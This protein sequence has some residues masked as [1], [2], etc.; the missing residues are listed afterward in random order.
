MLG[1]VPLALVAAIL[2]CWQSG[3]A[4]W[5]W[6]RELV[7]PDAPP[8]DYLPAEMPPNTSEL[9]RIKAGDYACYEVLSAP[10]ED[11]NVARRTTKIA[12]RAVEISASEVVLT[13]CVSV[14]DTERRPHPAPFATVPYINRLFKSTGIEVT[15]KPIAGEVR[16]PTSSLAGVSPIPAGEWQS[17]KEPHFE[18]IGVDFESSI[19]TQAD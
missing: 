7:A 5:Q 9:A 12:G 15:P 14:G 19:A 13:D 4:S 3:C 2:A 1:R 18:R 8:S 17:Y 11:A 10:S 6:N 16:L